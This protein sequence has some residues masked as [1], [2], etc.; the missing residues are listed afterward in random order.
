MNELVD[1]YVFRVM[2]IRGDFKVKWDEKNRLIKIDARD[3]NENDVKIL[4]KLV[5][6]GRKKQDLQLFSSDESWKPLKY[7]KK[8]ETGFRFVLRRKKKDAQDF[9]ETF[10]AE[11]KKKGYSIAKKGDMEAAVVPVK[12]G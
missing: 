3:A 11:L 7:K 1:G 2:N 4:Q 6:K 12:G 9:F 5:E 10:K 8:V